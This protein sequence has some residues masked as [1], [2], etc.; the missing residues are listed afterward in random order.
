MSMRH[1]P[2]PKPKFNVGDKVREKEK[3]T[4]YLL[5]S[6]ASFNRFNTFPDRG[7]G[8]VLR[9][10]VKKNKRGSRIFHME[11][12][13]ETKAKCIHVQHRLVLAEK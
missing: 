2:E 13:W 4:S 10:I 7:V 9:V 5:A 11:V 1:R 3:P 8:T 6:K 12:E